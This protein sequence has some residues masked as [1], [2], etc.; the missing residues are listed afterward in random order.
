MSG[1]WAAGVSWDNHEKRWRATIHVIA[2]DGDGTS[3]PRHLGAFI[4]EVEA[5]LAYDQ[6]AREHDADES[7]LNFP[8]LRP[9]PQEGLR[10]T[11]SQYRGKSRCTPQVDGC[12]C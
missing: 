1:A 8:Y 4:K 7:K 10:Q 5:A 2:G 6:A 3:K 9:Q 12:R 11:P